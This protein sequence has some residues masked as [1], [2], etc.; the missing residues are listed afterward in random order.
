VRLNAPDYQA[1]YQ[2]K[3]REAVRFKHRRALVLTARKLI[4]LVFALLLK[5]ESYQHPGGV[6]VN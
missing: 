1:F 6:A 5:N 2:R 4:R 3:Y